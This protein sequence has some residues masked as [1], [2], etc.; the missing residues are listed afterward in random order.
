MKTA[1]KLDLKSKT[2][3]S[4]KRY[5]RLREEEIILIDN[6]FYQK[7]FIIIISLFIILILPESPKELAKI[8][9]HYNS[10]TTCNVW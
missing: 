6:K 10:R 7:L 2:F 1:I 8:C 4:R 9:N 5:S 3:Y